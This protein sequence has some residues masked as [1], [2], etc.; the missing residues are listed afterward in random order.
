MIILIVQE[1]Y[2]GACNGQV[3]EP[4]LLCVGL[5]VGDG[6]PTAEPARGPLPSSS[7]ADDLTIC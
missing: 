6:G 2:E 4:G 7:H 1:L 3:A 5:P